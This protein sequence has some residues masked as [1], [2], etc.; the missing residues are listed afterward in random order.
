ME[1]EKRLLVPWLMVRR[2]ESCIMFRYDPNYHPVTLICSCRICGAEF[3]QNPVVPHDQW[4]VEQVFKG[5]LTT[6]VRP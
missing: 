5:R 2:R 1:I 4:K 3:G 6:E